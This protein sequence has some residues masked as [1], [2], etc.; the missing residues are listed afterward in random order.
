MLSL[1]SKITSCPWAKHLIPNRSSGAAQW[2]VVRLWLH[3][4]APR[5]VTA[6]MWHK[7]IPFKGV[8]R[9]KK[10]ND[11]NLHFRW[12]GNGNWG[13]S[14]AWSQKY[15]SSVLWG[16]LL[17]SGQVVVHRERQNPSGGRPTRPRA[18]VFDDRGNKTQHVT[19]CAFKKSLLKWISS[20]LR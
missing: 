6:W 4:A 3:R 16:Q 13:R 15:S 17:N 19:H 9:Y 7:G 8:W 1:L 11:V 20:Q 5:C 12:G 18:S 14:T 2:P 10:K